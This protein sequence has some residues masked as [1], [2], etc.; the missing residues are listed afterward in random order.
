MIN[1]QPFIERLEELKEHMDFY[2]EMLY[3]SQYFKN[4][5]IIEE[6]TDIKYLNPHKAG[7]AFFDKDG[8]VQEIKMFDDGL[9]AAKQIKDNNE[10][11]IQNQ[12]EV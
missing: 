4:C 1:V 12:K 9:M 11:D 2:I 6:R 3:A 5:H 8:M 7:I 10:K